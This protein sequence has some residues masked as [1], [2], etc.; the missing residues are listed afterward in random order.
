VLKLLASQAAISLENAYL[1]ADLRQENL[2]RERAEEALR[3]SEQVS[4]GQVEALTFSLDVLA[5]ASEPQKYLARML[6]IICGQLTGQS[7]SL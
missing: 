4:R 5:T 1:Y 3:A 2:D 7:A 6:S